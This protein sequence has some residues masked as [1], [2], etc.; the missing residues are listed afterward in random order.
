MVCIAAVFPVNAVAPPD[1]TAS[2]TPSATVSTVTAKPVISATISTTTPS[3]GD[4][5]TISGIATGG[6][7]VTSVRMWVFAGSYLDVSTVPVNADGTYSKTFQTS[8][9]PPATYYVFI[10]SPGNTGTF[11][12]ELEDAGRYSGQVVNVKDGSLL[13]NFTGT[14]SVHDADAAV[15]L[16]EALIR[17]NSDDVYTKVIFQLVAPAATPPAATA[18]IP[19]PAQPVTT[20]KS[21]VSPVTIL[22]G[23]GICSVAVGLHSRK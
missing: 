23:L 6:N 12:I 14:G 4:P 10:Q 19:V 18:T 1:T 17:T 22:A 7:P 2:P 11:D 16:S 13:V 3:V 9:Y 15:A 8:G 21:P 5:V 20:T